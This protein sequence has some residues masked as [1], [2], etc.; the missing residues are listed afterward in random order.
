MNYKITIPEPCS[1]DWNTMSPTQKGAFCK[2]CA[3]EV[4]DFTKTTKKEFSRKIANGNNICGRFRPEQLN[5]PL[6]I[7]MSQS[8]FR[9]KAAMLGFTSLLAI[10]TPLAAQENMKP[11][12]VEHQY[13]VGRIA[14]RPV[15]T[16]NYTLTG[17]IKDLNETPLAD[18]NLILEGTEIGTKTNKKGEFSLLVPVSEKL[19]KQVLLV[20][21]LGYEVQ[22]ITIDKET[23]PLAIS[24]VEEI[25]ILGEIAIQEFP[26][27]KKDTINKVKSLF[28]KKCKK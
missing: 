15:Q 2:N 7:T 18:V 10:G 14:P 8:N 17:V 20:S 27:K 12:K 6:Q 22:K 9:R 28:R 4:I 19:E 24:M 16:K 3:K 25:M 23:K 1:E 21:Y 26:E 11:T 13:V 5:T